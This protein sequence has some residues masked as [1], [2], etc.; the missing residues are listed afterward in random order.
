[1]KRCFVISAVFWCLVFV[2]TITGCASTPKN[3]NPLANTTWAWVN[4]IDDNKK[5]VV[6]Y[7]DDTVSFTIYYADGKV[8]QKPVSGTYS[9]SDNILTETYGDF[10]T[11]SILSRNSITDSSNSVIEFIKQKI[12]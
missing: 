11:T 2:L 12:N 10:T 3:S 1:M 6:E 5:Y 7:S 9:L 4:K 8:Y